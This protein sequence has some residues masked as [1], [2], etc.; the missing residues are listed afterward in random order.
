MKF[1]PRR[2]VV[3]IL[4]V[5]VVCTMPLFAQDN[6]PITVVGSGIVTPLF[7]TL[8]QASGVT[9]NLTVNVTGTNNGFNSLC[10]GEA[11]IA[12]ANRTIN[13]AEATL[14]SQG[15]IEYIEMPIAYDAIAFIANADSAYAQCLNIS[16]LNTVLAP[17]ATGQMNNWN[18][19][20]ADNPDLAISVFAPALDTPGYVILDALIDG[21][22]LRLDAAQLATDT[23][24]IAAVN[25]TPGAIGI[26][27]YTPALANDPNVYILNLQGGTTPGCHFPTAEAI[28]DG[29]YFAAEILYLYIRT[30]AV[31]K[32][33]L[34]DILTYI[35]GDA[36]I[37]VVE[38]AG[39]VA[40][41][42][43]VKERNLA[44]LE[45]P[46]AETTSEDTRFTIQPAVA[47]T[48]RVGGAANGAGVLKVMSD[49]FTATYAGVSFD[50]NVEGQTDGY[51]RLCNG[52]IDI[53]VGARDLTAEELQNC[54]A[55]NITL[56][57][58]ELGSQA[59]V[60]L[61]NP[62]STYAQCLSTTQINTI[63]RA[64]P[65][66]ETAITQWSQV[67]TNFPAGIPLTLFA[68]VSRSFAIQPDVTTIYGDLLLSASGIPGIIRED[69]ALAN[70]ERFANDPVYRA[71][72][73]GNTPGSLTYMSWSDWQSVL[74]DGRVLL[75]GQEP[76]AP[77][78][79]AEATAEAS[80]T[81]APEMTA[82]VA[83]ESAA[84]ATAAAESTAE[85]TAVA[86]VAP[87]P[88]YYRV[89]LVSVAPV[90]ADGTVGA[91]VLPDE[92]NIESGMY[93]LTSP[94]RLVI[95]QV[96]LGRPDVQSFLW[97]IF[98]T[99]YFGVLTDLGLVG[100]SDAELPD[101]RTRLITEFEAGNAAA[102]AAAEATA[103]ATGEA[104][105]EA[106]GQPGVEST[107][108]PG[109]E[110]TASAP[111]ESTPDATAEATPGS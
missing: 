6:S 110:A 3:A 23:E 103:E 96:S 2:A 61:T 89:Q 81:V 32:P 22:G 26:V 70:Q 105:S 39:F 76:P 38:G 83:P 86:S 16:D 63:W 78:A 91:C 84:E 108:Q 82:T 54:T 57:T 97:F 73:V 102:R 95:N 77:E 60:L 29:L 24:I 111:A 66:T 88:A 56:V 85:A 13:S 34:R 46:A 72:A 11:D 48:V 5:L 59:T 35:N 90:N 40:P 100:I 10:T 36:A 1:L 75:P 106:T 47:G 79:T 15:T 4:L 17:S 18:Q 43:T 87:P 49:G 21:S 98:Q 31:E 12:T 53:A 67:G 25:A 50:Y 74:E 64:T 44:R 9:A 19:I 52:E 68:P 51:R 7:Q 42:A 65:P 27:R 8:V 80:A 28:E 14:C 41:S 107:A 99:Q 101:V 94:V 109:A 55:N 69:T 45:N 30:D 20:Y 58:I 104:T 93:P 92:T 33:G 71:M 37:S 62:D